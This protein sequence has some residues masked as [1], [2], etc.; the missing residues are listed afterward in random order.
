[1]Q[2][3][4]TK[5]CKW[6]L[7]DCDECGSTGLLVGDQTDSSI[8]HDCVKMKRVN[9]KER[10]KKQEACNQVQP[11]SRDFPKSGDGRDLPYLNPGDK[12]VIAPVHPVVT[13]KKNSY[14]D[15]RLRLESISLVQDPV[16]TWCKILP[17]TS[18]AGRFMIIE[19]RVQNSEKYIIANPDHVRQWL[20]Y[21]FANHKDF[22]RLSTGEHKLLEIN[23]AAIE[24][25]RPHLELAEVD[26]G[27]AD[28]TRADT[29]Q[30][31]GEDEGLTD[32]TV[33]SGFSETHVFSFD[34]YP[35]LYLKTRHHA[36]KKARETGNH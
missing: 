13:V 11:K 7:I 12:A 10:K 25:F 6:Q 19:R 30:P 8:C 26:S 9:E 18:L 27:L 33:S 4:V 14:A 32:P 29:Q 15:K 21:L 3:C 5:E 24:A 22:V 2:L 17:R 16:P 31:E 28:C 35:E 36:Y 1:M 34:R 23:E 20:R